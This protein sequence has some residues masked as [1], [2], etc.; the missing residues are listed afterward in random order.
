MHVYSHFKCRSQNVSSRKLNRVCYW[1]VFHARNSAPLWLMNPCCTSVSTCKD[2][3][4]S[5]LGW[6]GDGMSTC[7]CTQKLRRGRGPL[8]PQFPRSARLFLRYMRDRCYIQTTTNLWKPWGLVIRSLPMLSADIHLCLVIHCRISLVLS[9]I[10][11]MAVFG[12]NLCR[13][14]QDALVFVK[15]FTEATQW[16]AWNYPSVRFISKFL[17]VTSVVVKSLKEKQ[18]LLLPSKIWTG[19]DTPP[20][21]GSL[22]P[23]QARVTF[24]WC[25]H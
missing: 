9:E 23:S 14:V 21:A 10:H 2:L 7:L 20:Y 17:S 8:I 3:H 1:I 13:F 24:A 11:F 5:N 6:G 22:F 19:D 12:M 4:F 15:W 18:R 25:D 16:C